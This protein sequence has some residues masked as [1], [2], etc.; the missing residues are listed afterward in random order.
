M[1]LLRVGRVAH[2]FSCSRHHQ[3]GCP[4]LALFARVGTR[5]PLNPG[6]G[7]SGDVHWLSKNRTRSPRRE[8]RRNGRGNYFPAASVEPCMRF[9]F[10]PLS[11][12]LLISAMAA[13]ISPVSVQNQA[14]PLGSVSGEVLQSPGGMPMGKVMVSLLSDG[15]MEFSFGRRDPNMPSGFTDA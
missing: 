6:F 8:S 2:P 14:P 3:R 7:L 9:A 13:Q 11:W 10:L 1:L 12:F 4:I 5:T 15:R